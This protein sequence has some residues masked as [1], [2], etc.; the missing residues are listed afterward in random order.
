ML[1]EILAHKREE[2][3][4]T[5][6]S[7][8]PAELMTRIAQLPSTRGFTRS[9]RGAKGMALIAEIK[10]RSP[11]KGVLANSVDVRATAGVYETGGA[12]AIS[13]LTDQRFFE[14]SLGDLRKVQDAVSLPILRKD[15]I[16][17]DQQVY[18]SRLAGA[19]AILLIVAALTDSELQNLYRLARSVG[20]DV[21]V[22]THDEPE[23]ER[24]LRV[25]ATVIGVNNRDL[26]TFD[27]SLEITERLAPL[28][29][30]SALCVAESG[31]KT[32]EDVERLRAVGVRALLVGETLMR[33][34]DPKAK[35]AELLGGRA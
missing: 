33:A 31:I 30:D 8:P 11:S 12:A 6:P 19:D 25:G 3:K 27:V 23:V 18:E 16:I 29:V 34:A 5:G 20:L 26:N 2:L 24:A 35:M 10:R 17:S 15:F 13:V 21:L 28:I 14:G 9:L 4:S 1:R 32:A 22:E 7:A